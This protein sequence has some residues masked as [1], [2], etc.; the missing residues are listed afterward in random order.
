EDTGPI[1]GQRAFAI[2]PDDTLETIRKKGLALE[3]QLYPEC[4]QLFAED[5]IKTVKKTFTLK[6]GQKLQ[7]TIVEILPSIQ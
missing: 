5:R 7:R 6:N 2:A 3:W 4:I 1:I